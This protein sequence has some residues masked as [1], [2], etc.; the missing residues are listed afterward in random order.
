[1]L[2]YKSEFQ[3]T[4]YRLKILNA[5]TTEILMELSYFLVYLKFGLVLSSLVSLF[6]RVMIKG[7]KSYNF[8]HIKGPK[9][10]NDGLQICIQ[11]QFS[12]NAS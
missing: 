1:M 7:H 6:V 10:Q 9:N 5:K 12:N 8:M 4:L 2:K 11:A 3:T